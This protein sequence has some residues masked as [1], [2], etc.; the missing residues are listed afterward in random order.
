MLPWAECQPGRTY[1]EVKEGCMR[2]ACGRLSALAKP[3]IML[4]LSVSS[5]DST[6]ALNTGNRSFGAAATADITDPSWQR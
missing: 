3:Q 4:F 1:F 2:M 5:S 6:T